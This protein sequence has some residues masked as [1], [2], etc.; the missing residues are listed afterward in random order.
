MRL[1]ILVVEDTNGE[2]DAIKEHVMQQ[3]AELGMSSGNP[4]Q[5]PSSFLLARAY[6]LEGAR[7]AIEDF[8]Q[9][10]DAAR[11]NH[12]VYPGLLI[13]FDILLLAAANESLATNYI[14][15]FST[16]TSR[17]LRFSAAGDYLLE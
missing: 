2:Y 10:E 11:A 1:N 7:N 17:P 14:T 15:T 13:I 3:C 4:F 16:W 12:I 9:R 5:D 8:A 6:N